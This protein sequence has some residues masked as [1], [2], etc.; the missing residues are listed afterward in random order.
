MSS[1]MEEDT[2]EDIDRGI[3]SGLQRHVEGI[4]VRLGLNATGFKTEVRR[5]GRW[6]YGCAGKSS[7]LNLYLIVPDT[8]ASRAREIRELLGATLES[9]EEAKGGGKAPVDQARNSTLKWTS[10]TCDRD[11]SLLVAVEK[12]NA[13]GG[14][15]GRT[16]STNQIHGEKATKRLMETRQMIDNHFPFIINSVVMDDVIAVVKA[17][18]VTDHVEAV[19]RAQNIW[20]QVCFKL[21][22]YTT[23]DKKGTK[24]EFM[25][26]WLQ[27]GYTWD[28]CI[29]CLETLSPTSGLK[30][31]YQED[32]SDSAMLPIDSMSS[33]IPRIHVARSTN[34][35]HREKAKKRL[36]KTRQMIDRHP[37]FTMKWVVMDDV[38]AEVKAAGVTDH[39]DAVR[40]AQKS[41]EH[42]CFTSEIY[43]TGDKEGTK[44]EFMEEWLHSGYTWDAC[45]AHLQTLSPTGGVKK[46]FGETFRTGSSKVA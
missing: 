42:V 18:G 15:R 25:F 40:R 45:I 27:S 5:M 24:A 26:E 20:D 13:W 34:Q 2:D 31:D 29:A 17:A 44:A 39:V 41:W 30:R 28:A 3:I 11:V 38:I 9:G 23:G 1:S 37:S 7:D 19:R 35:I 21:D 33:K 12:G 10:T 22:I 8:W 6:E 43:S 16:R 4:V 14:G 32:D 36:K 46:A